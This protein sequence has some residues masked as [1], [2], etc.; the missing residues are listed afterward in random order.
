MRTIRFSLIAA[1]L[2]ACG[3]QFAA[4]NAPR[5]DEFPAEW[6]F[7]EAERPAQ[8]K[9]LEGKTAPALALKDWIGEEQTLEGLRG[10]IVVIDFWG[11]WC[12]PCMKALPENV[13]L[14]DKY[15]DKGVRFLG[16]H[17]SKRG[18]EK[19]PAVAKEKK[20]NYP[21]AV[22]DG[23][24]SAKAYQVRFWPTYVVIDRLGVVRAAGLKP[25]SVEKVIEK[26]L[27]EKPAAG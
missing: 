19:M 17:D 25:D 7:Y 2:L 4:A 22:D 10:K 15:R 3:L 24:A 23:G 20:L 18:F 8:L 6:Y 9:S 12:P 21:L 26:L 11:T 5:A 13:V 1:L 16:V 27:E 14:A